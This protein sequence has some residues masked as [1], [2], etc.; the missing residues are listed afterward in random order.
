MNPLN[1]IEQRLMALEIKASYAEDTVDQ[2]NLIVVRQQQEI[3]SLRDVVTHLRNQLLAS[4]TG[5]VR[6][7]RD[8]LPPHY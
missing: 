1:D 3:D 7:L 6:S 2:L 8:E 4:D 5:G